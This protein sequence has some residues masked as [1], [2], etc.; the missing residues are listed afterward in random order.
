MLLPT[1]QEPD[2]LSHGQEVCRGQPLGHV[3]SLVT[4]L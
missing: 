2:V 3:M 4:V 1:L